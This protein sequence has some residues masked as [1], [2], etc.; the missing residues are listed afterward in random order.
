MKPDDI[1]K[2]YT[3]ARDRF[4]GLGVD[5][6]QALRTLNTVPLSLNCWQ[7]DDVGG[8]ESPGASLGGGGLAVTG[9]WP[10]RARTPDELRTDLEKAMSLIP[11]PHRVNLHAIYGEF[12]GKKVDRDAIGPEHFSGWLEWAKRNRAALDFN[13]TCF[14]HPKSASGYTLSDSDAGIRRFWVEHCRRARH[15]GAHLGRELGN[16]CV[17]NLWIPDGAKDATVSRWR[18][19]EFLRQSLDQVFSTRHEEACLLDA[20]E[21]KLFGIGSESFVTGSHEFYLAYAVKNGLMPC[22]DMGHYHPTE[23]VAD[24]VSAILQFV[25]GILVHVSR[26]V[27]WDS[28]HVVSLT[29][30]LTA[31]MQEIVRI[32]AL[33]RTHLA[34]D[35]FDASINRVGAWVSGARAAQKALLLALLEPGKKLREY[36]DKGN[37]FGRLALL[38]E[39]K[40]LPWGAVWDYHCS[41]LNVLPGAEWI[42]EILAYEKEVLSTRR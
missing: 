32:P 11:G 30:E 5:T 26:G 38:E 31:L 3:E 13:A 1:K 33:D 41:D 40:A 28:D 7:G 27:R 21:G 8:F 18:H 22:L 9:N 24:K 39:A 6:D 35:Y 2:G 15:I 29:D 4:A 25:P 10:G 14:S 16:P 36:E 37:N 34:L 19:R 17:H 20:V 42:D 12:G 23:S